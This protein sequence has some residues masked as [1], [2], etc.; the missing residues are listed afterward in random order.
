MAYKRPN[1]R[2]PNFKGK[3]PPPPPARKKNT[4]YT[5]NTYPR[6]TWA[7]SIAKS[8]ECPFGVLE[9]RVLAPTES[10]QRPKNDRVTLRSV[11]DNRLAGVSTMVWVLRVPSF[12]HFPNRST[13]IPFWDNSSFPI[14]YN[15]ESEISEQKIV[16]SI[17]QK[18]LNSTFVRTNEK[19][20]Q[21]K[22][23]N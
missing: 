19:N 16:K 15:G 4:M 8:L 12:T 18:N 1:A 22:L 9:G 21:E 2:P 10:H 11:P 6:S 7:A 3:Y 20:I 5:R 23:K 14:W 13:M 17:I